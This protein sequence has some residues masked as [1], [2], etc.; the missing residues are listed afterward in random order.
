MST[1]RYSN[2]V[3]CVASDRHSLAALPRRCIRPPPLGH[4][5]IGPPFGWI[6]KK[7]ASTASP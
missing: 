4:S 5:F 2:A 7:M 6:K 1:R 3:D